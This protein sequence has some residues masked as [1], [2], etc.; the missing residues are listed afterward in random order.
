MFIYAAFAWLCPSFCSLHSWVV[1]IAP[2]CWLPVLSCRETGVIMGF[3]RKPHKKCK[4]WLN[5]FSFSEVDFACLKFRYAVSSHLCSLMGDVLPKFDVCI[6]CGKTM[7]GLSVQY[8][9]FFCVFARL[10]LVLLLHWFK[11]HL[12][13]KEWYLRRFQLRFAQP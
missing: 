8:I 12:M 9:T 2:L 4:A 1:G 3:R 6:D 13:P 10:L 11:E 5:S 7:F